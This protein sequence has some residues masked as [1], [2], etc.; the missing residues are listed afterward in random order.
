M[1]VGVVGA[2]AF[3]VGLAR[4]SARGG[5]QVS[6][7]S[8]R[9]ESRGNEGVD[10]V[11]SLGA[12][13]AC[14]LIF[15]AVPSLVVREV[16]TELGRVLDGRH[17]LVHVSRGLVGDELATVGQVLRTVTP[18]RRIGCLGGPLTADVLREGKPGG[19]VIGSWFSEVTDAVRSAIGGKTLRLYHTEDLLGVELSS[20]LV[21]LVAIA[22]GFAIELDFGPGSLAVM[23][24]RGLAEATRFG[25]A[26]GADERTFAGMSGFGDLIAAVG[27]DE[28][29]EILLGRALARGA[30]LTTAGL[31]ARAHVESIAV[32]RRLE[33][34]AARR[35]LELPIT[36]AMAD[37]IE[38]KTP[39]LQALERLM[40]RSARRE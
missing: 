22:I 15:V 12:L 36:S 40:S 2:G 30:S 18:C 4:A 21:G 27:G 34:E 29:P 19:G 38:G 28:R 10:V 3:G 32:A 39:H 1:R 11:D 6:L 33:R 7:Y 31:E 23:A 8:R 16:A 14:E 25:V 35:G 37:V 20:A 13:E 9:G 5:H 24:T 17:Y 26:K